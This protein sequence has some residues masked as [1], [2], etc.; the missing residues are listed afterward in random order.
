MPHRRRCSGHRRTHH[1]CR[2]HCQYCNGRCRLPPLPLELAL[3]S[4]LSLRPELPPPEL[5]PPE[6]PLPPP[7]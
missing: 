6:L 4:E 2:T 3:L 7:P 5:P 1:C